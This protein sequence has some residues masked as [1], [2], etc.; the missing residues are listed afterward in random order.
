[1]NITEIHSLDT[2]GVEVF[3][4]LTEAQ[5][6]SRLEPEK[7]VF[8]AESP[9][10]IRVALDAGF[11]PISLLCERRHLTGDAADILPRLGDIPVYV[12][13]RELLARLTGYTL[14]RGVLCAMRRPAPKRVEEVCREARRGFHEHWGHIPFRCGLGHRCRIAHPQLLRPAEPSCRSGLYGQRIPCSLGL[15]RYSVGRP[16][17]VRFSHRGYGADGQLHIARL[18]LPKC[19]P[20]TGYRDGHRGR[21]LGP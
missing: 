14:T 19:R 2:P 1:M 20:P 15:A 6:R 7:G 11:Q 10:V 17:P 5:L 8:I 3:G 4:T 12:G 18:S 13:E 9:K 21:R 16:S